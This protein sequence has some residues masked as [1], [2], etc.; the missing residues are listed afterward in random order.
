MNQTSSPEE[1]KC[2]QWEEPD[3]AVRYLKI[4]TSMEMGSL[5]F[6]KSV[7]SAVSGTPTVS[8]LSELENIIKN[9]TGIFNSNFGGLPIL[10]DYF[11]NVFEYDCSQLTSGNY[12]PEKFIEE[13]D[14][15][16]M[17]YYNK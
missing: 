3:L 1:R 16:T 6:E 2:G 14:K 8:E 5:E 17:D 4:A 15:D 11:V 9:A 7:H 12:S 13:L 10:G